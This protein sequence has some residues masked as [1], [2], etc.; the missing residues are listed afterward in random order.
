MEEKTKGLVLALCST[1]MIGSSFIIKKKG[2][3]V[4]GASGIRAGLGGYSYLKEPVWWAGMTT[5]VLGE[6]FNFAAYAF[7]PA[8]LVTPLGALSI[9]V[10]AVLADIVLGERLH[11]LGMMGCALCVVGS[12]EIVL[13]A[14][15]EK[16]IASVHQ[17][18][19]LACAPP[20]LMYAC[21]AVGMGALLIVYVVPAN[22]SSQMLVYIAICSLF[23]SLSVMSCKALGIA[24][25][26]TFAGDNQLTYAETY[27]FA[28][29]VAACV[30]TQ[31]NYLN[32]A[33][34][35]FNTAVVSPIYYVMFTVLTIAASAIMFKEW[36]NQSATQIA[37]E[38]CG[39]LTIL[40]GTFLLHATKDFGGK[41]SFVLKLFDDIEGGTLDDV[42]P[43]AASAELTRTRL[44]G[45]T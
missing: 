34:D 4:A 1:I 23:G 30:L 42:S 22:G 8:V 7:A 26:L 44:I 17:V 5:M 6:V 13:H 3:R 40:A 41:R 28:A 36:E 10:S 31:M 14:P 2:L 29:V 25:K 43:T 37:S 27:I 45:E 15:E 16:A 9:L 39:F 35:M 24:L 18:W 33:L 12:V 11:L 19:E 32:K 20:F 21:I 38:V